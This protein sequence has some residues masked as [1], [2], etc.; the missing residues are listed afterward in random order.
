MYQGHVTKTFPISRSGQ[1]GCPLSMQL[2][3]I[4]TECFHEM[5]IK[6]SNIKGYK[7]PNGKQK[8][9]L[10]YADDIIL[11]IENTN[12]IPYIFDTFKKYSNS[13]GAIINKNKTEV[14]WLEKWSS[15]NIK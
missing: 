11:I 1:Q 6:N 15:I 5:V 4:C 8:K 3:V 7:L 12:S 14:I 2:F 9:L 13:S 10:A